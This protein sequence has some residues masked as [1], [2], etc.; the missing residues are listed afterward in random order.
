MIKK[1]LI[2]L[3]CAMSAGLCAGRPALA[4]SDADE[5]RMQ[6]MQRETDNDVVKRGQQK[7]IEL[8]SKQFQLPG[9]EIEKFRNG[10][11]GWGEVT[12]R[13]ALADKLTKTDPTNFPT[14]SAA[15]ERIGTLRDDG[16]GWGS[17]SKE[18]GFKLGPLISDVRHSMNELRRDLHQDQLTAGKGDDRGDIQRETRGE[19]MERAQRPERLERL[20]RPERP[21]KPERPDRPE[22]PEHIKR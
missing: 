2:F 5:T 18:L 14:L 22:K 6:A 3:L 16:K 1:P 21:E 10:G 20:E 9:S 19:R 12:I 17:I 8:L 11:Q 13:L 15:Q 4:Q 7:H